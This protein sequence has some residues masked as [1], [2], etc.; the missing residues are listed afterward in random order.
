MKPPIFVRTLTAAERQQLQ[1]GLRS[2]AAFTVRRCQILLASAN[3]QRA[4]TIARNLGCAVGTVHN[5]RRA[6]HQAGLACLQEQSSRP[7]TAHPFLDERFTEALKDL[8]HH[9]PRLFGKPTSLWTL[10]LVAAVCHGK[11]WTPRQLTG[12]AIRVALRRLGIRWR[13]A[14]HWITSPDPGYARKKK[15]A[16]A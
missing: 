13:R 15:P 10:D 3:G 7:Q 11:G 14:K 16:I 2:A 8:L 9:S 1:A 12:E 4:S 5:A 6:F